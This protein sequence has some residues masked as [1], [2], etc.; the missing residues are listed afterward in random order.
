MGLSVPWALL[1]C[2]LLIPSR[3]TAPWMYVKTNP[4]TLLVALSLL[5]YFTVNDRQYNRFCSQV[6]LHSSSRPSRSSLHD[7][8][9]E[10]ALCQ[11]SR[12]QAEWSPRPLQ[13]GPTTP[14]LRQ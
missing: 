8:H 4:C 10:R 7:K 9:R 12:P 1:G 13:A 6:F 5:N 14:E 3:V 11:G 2:R